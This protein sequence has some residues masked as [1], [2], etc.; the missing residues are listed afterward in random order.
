MRIERVAKFFLITEGISNVL[1]SILIFYNPLIILEIFW[2][3]VEMNIAFF[4]L[5]RWFSILV[6]SFSGLLLYSMIINYRLRYS[7]LFTFYVADLIFLPVN[8]ISLTYTFTW[9]SVFNILWGFI[10]MISRYHM[11]F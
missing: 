5:V 4:D 9:S 1:I 2:P 7:V 11:I 3:T 6:F 8:I 10:L